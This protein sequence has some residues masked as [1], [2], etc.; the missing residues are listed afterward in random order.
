MCFW[1]RTIYD[2]PANNPASHTCLVSANT[3]LGPDSTSGSITIPAN[4]S[5]CGLNPSVQIQQVNV[6]L[7]VNGV[8]GEENLV[9]LIYP[10]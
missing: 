7:G 1:P 8:H 6:F 4:M 3:N 9:A 2:G 5:A 10:Y